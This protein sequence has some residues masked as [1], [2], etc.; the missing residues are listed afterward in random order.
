[1]AFGRVWA[2]HPAKP[3]LSTEKASEKPCRETRKQHGMARPVRC[4]LLWLT[5]SGRA[6]PG[7]Q[8]SADLLACLFVCLVAACLV[9][10]SLLGCLVDWLVIWLF[11]YCL[12]LLLLLLLSFLLSLLL[13][14]SHHPR[15]WFLACPI[16]KDYCIF[17]TRRYRQKLQGWLPG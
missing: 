15:I 14:C 2:S 12:L 10:G 7:R 1:M 11:A 13:W 17:L 9:V 3:G 6:P 16:I 4:C 8:G 5:A